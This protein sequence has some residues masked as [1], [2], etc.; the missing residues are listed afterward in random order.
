MSYILNAFFFPFVAV[1]R[2]KFVEIVVYKV[3][4]VGVAIVDRVSILPAIWF[5]QILF[6]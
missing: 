5:I 3:I 6:F 1:D 4:L 2:L